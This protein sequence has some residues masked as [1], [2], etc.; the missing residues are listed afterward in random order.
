M[1]LE[2]KLNLLIDTWVEWST[3]IFE[4]SKTESPSLLPKF[5][6]T[7]YS[8]KDLE[9]QLMLKTTDLQRRLVTISVVFSNFCL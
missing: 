3:E 2:C 9:L 1:Q 7:R 6:S 5:L 8:T 4:F